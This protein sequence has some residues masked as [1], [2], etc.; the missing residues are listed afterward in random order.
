MRAC[1]I[2]LL[3]C[4]AIMM[5]PIFSALGITFAQLLK[6]EPDF[7]AVTYKATDTQQL[8]LFMSKPQG[9]KAVDHRA[10]VMCIH[11]GAWL[12]GEARTLFPLAGYFTSRGAVGISIEYRLLTPD[13]VSLADCIAD[14][15]S[16]I[17]YIRAH[18]AELGINPDKIAVLGD[19]AGGHLAAA[20]GMCDSV[21]APGGDA[22]ISAVP[23]AMILCNP[24]V[25]LTDGDWIKFVMRGETL[26]SSPVARGLHPGSAQLEMACVL[27]PLFQVR[28]GQP[29]TLLMH[30]L[31]DRIVSPD[32]ARKFAAAMES[33][34]NRCD[35]VLIE[36]ASHAFVIP[37]YR[38]PE[39]VVVDALRR[40]DA[41][42][43]SAGFLNGAPTLEISSPPAW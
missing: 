38:E 34:G 11:G 19:S 16:A 25:D 41:F 15:K 3:A 21:D 2:A 37:R 36:K 33:A 22:A 26:A 20:L 13:G 23:D 18:S 31:D 7:H 8:R 6:A 9:W 5:S 30:G 40:A 12:G 4:A 10:V 17:R 28:A 32:Q 14:C 35:L 1:K 27:S 43:V 42:L 29:P 39:R 24:I